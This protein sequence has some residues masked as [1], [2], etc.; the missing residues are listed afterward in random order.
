MTAGAAV[1]VL[2]FS[3]LKISDFSVKKLVVLAVALFV[4]VLVNRY[5]TV[6]P[7]TNIRFSPKHI[8]AFWGV[9]CLGVGG[10][11]LLSAS[12][13]LARLTR[14]ENGKTKS[15]FEASADVLATYLSGVTFYLALG[16]FPNA[17]GSLSAGEL[18]NVKEILAAMSSMV[19]LH[20][21]ITAS[22]DYLVQRAG[23]RGG[24]R[25]LLIDKFL[26]PGLAYTVSFF[27]ALVIYG[28]FAKFG[29]EFGLVILPLSIVA[30]VAYRMHCR[31]L[32]EKT[33][34]ISEAAN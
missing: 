20:F 18:A 13:G 17:N 7:R 6:I 5:E 21:L 27:A 34:E 33:R 14:A 24:I 23:I 19:V 1:V 4:S 16:F 11:A 30:D 10:G 22:L 2:A 29:I 15:L 32:A 8:F 12:A 28:T 9:I 26:R 3:A 25:P 31:S